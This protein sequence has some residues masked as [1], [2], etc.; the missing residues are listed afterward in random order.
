M[1]RISKSCW[2]KTLRKEE[3]VRGFSS[4]RR[5][6]AFMWCAIAF[7]GFRKSGGLLI[8][9]GK[10]GSRPSKTFDLLKPFLLPKNFGRKCNREKMLLLPFLPTTPWSKIRLYFGGIRVA[11]GMQLDYLGIWFHPKLFLVRLLLTFW[12]IKAKP[13][14]PLQYI[15]H[16]LLF[17]FSNIFMVKFSSKLFVLSILATASYTRHKRISNDG[18]CFCG[19]GQ[20]FQRRKKPRNKAFFL[21]L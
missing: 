3:E 17:C 18:V 21:F 14:P 8:M 10:G 11:V 2:W 7:L 9:D 1:S 13:S 19:L 4:W 16:A 12:I 15:L 5:A 20:K 6:M